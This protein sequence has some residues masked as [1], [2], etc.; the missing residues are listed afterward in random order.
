MHINTLILVIALSLLAGL[1]V[2]ENIGSMGG[3]LATKLP[4]SALF[5]LTAVVQ[6]HP[7]P[8]YYR[9]ML[10][11]LVFCLLGDACL[12]FDR[13]SFFLTGLVAFLGGHLWYTAAFYNIVG[14]NRWT[15]VG[16][17]AVFV[18]AAIVSRWLQP[19]L[20][21]KMKGP[22]TAYIVVISLMLTVAVSLLGENAMPLRLQIM[23]PAGAL[24]FYISDLFVARNR[25]INRA[26]LNRLLGLPLYYTGQFLLAF[27]VSSPG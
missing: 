2:F 19:H 3:K 25:F 15:A 14:L 27:S 7:N 26:F 11:G 4:L 16:A 21:P 12:I 20:E 24:A 10:T 23:V 22:V 6:P 8:A 13:R 1:L 9:L 18:N 17:A 5:V